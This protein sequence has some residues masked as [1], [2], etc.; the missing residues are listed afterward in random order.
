MDGL[1]RPFTTVVSGLEATRAL[2][3]DSSQLRLGD[4]PEWMLKGQLGLW[5]WMLQ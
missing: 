3:S 5:K 1:V 4:S 2:K